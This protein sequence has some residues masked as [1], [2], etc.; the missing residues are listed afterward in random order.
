[1]LEVLWEI[2]HGVNDKS[3]ISYCY[4][5]SKITGV[6]NVGG[7][8]GNNNKGNISYS[9]NLGEIIGNSMNSDGD[10]FVG[11]ISRCKCEEQ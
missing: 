4:N 7:I 1:M 11:G 8:T 6:V 5:T 2:I 9:Y 3:N 10:S